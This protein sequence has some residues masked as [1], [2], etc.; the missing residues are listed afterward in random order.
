LNGVLIAEPSLVLR[1]GIKSVLS[2]TTD[3]FVTAEVTS[4]KEL[5]SALSAMEH[6][7]ILIELKLFQ[8]VGITA[9]RYANSASAAPKILVHSYAANLENGV[10]VL[11]SGGMGYLTKHC[12][13]SELKQAILTV[14]SGKPYVS[15]ALVE[16]LADSI[17]FRPSSLPHLTLTSRELQ[18]FKMLVVGMSI[19]AIAIQLDISSKTISTYKVRII[20][21]MR[22]PRVS[23]LVQYAIANKLL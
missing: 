16:E 22:L 12:S 18:V 10:S 14:A 19:S 13:P 21:K 2:E 17:C 15:E 5:L 20:K 7:V 23:N 11:K 6:D 4:E 3:I 8:S 9:L 1:L